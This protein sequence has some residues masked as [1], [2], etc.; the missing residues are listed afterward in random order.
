MLFSHVKNVRCILFI[1][2]S[3]DKTFYYRDDYMFV[4]RNTSGNSV[5]LHLPGEQLSP[6][7]S[8]CMFVLLRIKSYKLCTYNK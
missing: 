8:D 6:R 1:E 3:T 5:I 4:N 2:H 7:S